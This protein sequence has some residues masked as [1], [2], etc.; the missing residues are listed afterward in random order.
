MGMP[1]TLEVVDPGATE[2]IFSAVFAYFES[3]DERFSTYKEHSEMSKIN[4]HEIALEAA[5]EDMQTVFNLAEQFRLHTDGY[6]DIQHDG[7]IDPSGL[8]KG[9]AIFNAAEMVRQGGFKNFY[10]EAGGDFEVAG[11]NSAGQKWQVGIRSPFELHDIIKVLSISNRGVATSG[12]YV[13]GQHIYN[14]KADHQPITEVVSI[15]VIGPNIFSA[16]CFATTAF[17]MGKDG[18]HF[19]EKLKGYEGYMVDTDQHATYTSGFQ[20]YVNHV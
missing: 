16:D 9:W 20:R 2:E 4:R 10:V 11:R 7:Q 14:P 5:S 18:I 12:T 17:A 3:I 13:R 1:V 15:T 6:F 8:V 19:I